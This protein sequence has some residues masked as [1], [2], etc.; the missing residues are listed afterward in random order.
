MNLLY[1]VLCCY[2]LTQI[3]IYGKIFHKIRPKHHFFHC[4]M[5]IGFWVGIFLFALNSYTEL[6][7]FNYNFINL[8]LC[9]FLS[10]G[11][12]YVL[13]QVI[14]DNGFQIERS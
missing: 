3:L 12:S 14:G 9:G 7:T 6:F 1:F 11:T 10:S 5:C 8:F 2:G 4:P 13:C